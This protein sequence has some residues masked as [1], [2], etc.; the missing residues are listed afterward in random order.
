MHQ[1][2]FIRR[3]SRDAAR[4]TKQKILSSRMKRQ[5]LKVALMKYRVSTLEVYK[6]ISIYFCIPLAWTPC[7]Y[8]HTRPLIRRSALL[9]VRKIY[10]TAI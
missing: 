3:I 6:N 7:T 9:Y 1:V 10:Y 8:I 2:G 5:N 4:S